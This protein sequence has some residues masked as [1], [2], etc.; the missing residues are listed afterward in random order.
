MKQ[1]ITIGTDGSISG[2]QHKK[3]KGVDLRQFGRAEIER[4]SHIVWDD[5]AQLWTIEVLTG[6]HA[7]K[8]IT[9]KLWEEATGVPHRAE[10][11]DPTQGA[12]SR[13]GFFDYDDAVAVEV[14]FL[15]SL[16]RVGVF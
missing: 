8:W 10:L 3:G 2:L 4:A 15:N 9:A 13:L 11:V 14:D 1:V 16:R 5:M 12:D 7:G 6:P